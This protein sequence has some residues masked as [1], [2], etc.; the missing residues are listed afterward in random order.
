MKALLGFQTPGGN[1]TDSSMMP[2]YKVLLKTLNQET[3]RM[4]L[5]NLCCEYLTMIAGSFVAIVCRELLLLVTSH[6][7]QR[8]QQVRFMENLLRSGSHSTLAETLKLDEAGWDLTLAPLAKHNHGLYLGHAHN[9]NAR[10]WKRLQREM[11]SIIGI[12]YMTARVLEAETLKVLA[13]FEGP[14]QSPYS[15]GVFYLILTY[16]DEYPLNPPTARFLTPIY[17]PNISHSGEICMDILQ[18]GW[19]PHMHLELIRISLISLLSDP[20]TDDPLVP[21]IAATYV[22]DRGLYERNARNYTE[23]Y[24]GMGQEY[25]KFG[26]FPAFSGESSLTLLS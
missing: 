14:P 23:K 8:E 4:L 6:E 3:R 19:L 7:R 22:Q 16:G 9:V 1:E 13:T 10:A 11:Q 25:Q 20:A 17:H 2:R 18:E 5:T 12:P 24:A 21:E 26:V 15:N